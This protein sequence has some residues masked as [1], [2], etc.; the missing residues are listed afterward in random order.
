MWSLKMIGPEAREA[1]PALIA[2]TRDRTEIMRVALLP[3]FGSKTPSRGVPVRQYAAEAIGAIGPEAAGATPRLTELLS[4]E[5]AEVRM[6]AAE[7]LG[8]IGPEAKAAAPALC[9]LAM[10]ESPRVRIAANIALVRVGTTD[11]APLLALIAALGTQDCDRCQIARGL[12]E[13]GPAAREAA[14]ALEECVKEGDFELRR[15][16]A[17]VLKRIRGAEA[18]K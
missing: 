18:P 12:L 1:L 17:E 2:A 11:P 8:H 5:L 16:A 7:A 15:I 10:D 4:D 14:P 3:V 13:I 9:R 6:A